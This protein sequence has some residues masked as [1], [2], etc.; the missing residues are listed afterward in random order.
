MGLLYRLLWRMAGA[1]PREPLHML[2]YTFVSISRM[3]EMPEAVAVYA[4]I[5]SQF[6]IFSAIF[7]VME[8]G[9]GRLATR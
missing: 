8:M 3:V 1:N 2:L 6:L 7:Y 9:R 4:R 5:L